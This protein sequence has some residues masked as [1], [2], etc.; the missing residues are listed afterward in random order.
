MERITDGFMSKVDAHLVSL[1]AQ[2]P[3]Y[4]HMETT[5]YISSEAEE[6]EVRKQEE[7]DEMPQFGNSFSSDNH[8]KINISEQR[9]ERITRVTN[10]FMDKMLTRIENL[11]VDTLTFRD[12]PLWLI[13]ANI[14]QQFAMLDVS[15][16]DRLLEA[17]DLFLRYERDSR[18][19]QDR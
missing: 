2:F 14:L 11:D 5:T 1:F 16:N 7:A 17:L 9:N 6:T 15:D 3:D 13:A 8:K 18:S 4:T 12:I 19:R 10:E